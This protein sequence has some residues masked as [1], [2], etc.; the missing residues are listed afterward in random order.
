[1]AFAP[2]GRLFVR[3]QAGILRVIQNGVL[4]SQPFVTVSTDNQGERGLLGV[5]NA[6]LPWSSP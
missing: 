6:R 1:M 2:D 4:L 5:A 3:E